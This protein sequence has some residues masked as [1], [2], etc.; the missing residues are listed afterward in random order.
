MESTQLADESNVPQTPTESLESLPLSKQQTA[1]MMISVLVV[2]LC[3]IVYELIIA[4]V[5][6]YLLGNS[7]YQF[8]MTIGFFM[9]AM[10]IGSFISKWFHDGLISTFIAIEIIVALIG[11][12]CSSL[13]FLMFPYHAMYQPVMFGLIIVIGTLVGLEIP[14]LARILSR[15]TAWKESIANVLSLD[16][17]GA[18]VGSVAFPIVMLPNLGLFQSSFAIGLLNVGVAI[19]SIFVFG[20]SL[21]RFKTLLAA[22]IL[23]LV[24]LIVGLLASERLTKFA[25]SQMYAD[26]V[27]FLK[28]TPYQRIVVT[29]NS[30]NR[31]IRLYLD[32]HIQFASVDEY[33]YHEALVHPVMSA[34]GKRATVLILGGGDGLAVREVL[35]YKDVE[36][37][38]MVDIDPAITEFC[39]RFGPIVR[40]N[41]GSLDSEKLTVINEDAFSYL[42]DY[43]GRVD[44]EFERFDRVIID[45]PDPHNEVLDKLY[46]KEFYEIV[47]SCMSP[48]GYMVCQCSSPFFARKVFW[49]IN[50]TMEAASFGVTPYRVPM[51]SFGIWGFNL[52]SANGTPLKTA[53]IDPAMC[54][55]L[56][57]EIFEES[58]RFGKDIAR[59]DD[60]PINRTFEPK[61]YSLY[62]QSLKK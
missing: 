22:A 56:T 40:L 28:Q 35:K 23:V 5:S 38:T 30:K 50:N 53:Q 41:Q 10:G 42:L 6:S 12:F 3:G 4:A 17:L 19:V 62:V 37:I 58:Q 27:I 51:V 15:S 54:R 34:A 26:K 33:R 59:L 29:E 52:C 1:V 47:R 49:C 44:K 39:S 57:T 48:N 43:A 2:A 7:V 18:L 9:F 31:D 16:Y 8:S 61:L 13:L 60:S 46:S 21:R 25:E 24:C 45:L 14:L 55:F 36:R 20:K 32:K 11:G